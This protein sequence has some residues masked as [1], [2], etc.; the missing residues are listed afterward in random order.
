M[1]H[2]GSTHIMTLY[3]TMP[4]WWFSVVTSS[5]VNSPNWTGTVFF[6]NAPGCASE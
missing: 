4:T 5:S 2:F 6:G 1:S 3:Y